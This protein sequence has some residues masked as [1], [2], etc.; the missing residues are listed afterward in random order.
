MMSHK[1]EQYYTYAVA[2]LMALNGLFHLLFLRIPASFDEITFFHIVQLIA[3]HHLNPFID[4]WGYRPPV[5]FM[6]PSIVYSVA[7]PSLLLPRIEIVFFS[8]ISVYF[9]Y[10]LGAYVFT[11]RVGLS[12]SMLLVS[13][14]LFTVLSHKFQDPI[15]FTALFL[16]TLYYFFTQNTIRY[17][18]AA[19]LLVLTK[20]IGVVLPM[21]LTFASRSISLEKHEQMQL[22]K[23]SKLSL[24]IP[25][26]VFVIW[27][28]LNKVFLGWY[29][30]T[31]NVLLFDPKNLLNLQ[32]SL[33][34]FK[35]IMLDTEMW[36]ISVTI[37]IGCIGLYRRFIPFKKNQTNILVFF[38]SIIILFV[39][40][41][42]SGYHSK[43]YYLFLYPLFFLL[44][45]AFLSHWI[46]SSKLY[47]L[48]I[49]LIVGVFTSSQY[50]QIFFRYTPVFD[51]SSLAYLKNIQLIQKVVTTMQRTESN[52]FIV[53]PWYISEPLK[54][55]HNGYVQHALHV[56]DSLKCEDLTEE[57][58]RYWRE[59]GEKKSHLI[60]IANA[61]SPL[62][63]QF[64]GL[65]F[66]QNI[67]PDNPL[68]TEN[69][70]TIFALDHTK[71]LQ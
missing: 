51:E 71:A 41:L 12:S 14:P 48:I 10:K 54:N 63:S 60:Y 37:L 57:K 3:H 5:L 1:T 55:P 24:L 20:E 21:L 9:L 31:P 30:W 65:K 69:C 6:I 15:P 45:T 27:M 33:N 56:D 40:F 28:I 44:F 29:L 42:M 38:I 23:I 43:R 7:G 36:I 11:R 68:A 32:T 34:E 8:S 53:A 18:I 49:L 2:G 13:F 70:Y 67:C 66:Q 39:I 22:Y 59:Q 47:F 4:T 35:L 61:I 52:A 25:V 58:I 62:C 50:T 64:T 26:G 19:S 46:K 16:A 17:L